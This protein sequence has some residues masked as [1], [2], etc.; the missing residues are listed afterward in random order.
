M[1]FPPSATGVL[2]GEA[3]YHIL[4]KNMPLLRRL[5]DAVKR[6]GYAIGL[7]YAAHGL[8]GQAGAF[9][10]NGQKALYAAG[11]AAL[12]IGALKMLKRMF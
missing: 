4:V 6:A 7:F 3:T 5:P 8:D 12:A 10:E 1:D 11:V 2:A 9:A